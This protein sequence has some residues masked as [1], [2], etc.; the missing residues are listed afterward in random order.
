MILTEATSNPRSASAVRESSLLYSPPVFR[1]GSGCR[2][3]WGWKHTDW[4]GAWVWVP[5]ALRHRDRVAWEPC[6]PRSSSPGLAWAGGVGTG[7]AGHL[8]A[9]AQLLLWRIEVTAEPCLCLQ[10]LRAELGRHSACVFPVKGQECGPSAS[11][12]T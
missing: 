10:L 8:G 9:W 5:D 11:Y 1:F 6:P 2:G 4:A 7:L 3:R 12:M